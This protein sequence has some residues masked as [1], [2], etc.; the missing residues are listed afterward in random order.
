VTSAYVDLARAHAPILAIA[1]LFG[2]AAL[3]A[4]TPGARASWAMASF[5]ALI[6]AALGFDWALRVLLHDD[7]L[8]WSAEGLSLV[9]D[10][11]GVFALALLTVTA[12]VVVL[13]ALPLLE[14]FTSQLTPFACALAIA[15]AG[16]WC[17]AALAQDFT[18]FFLFVEIA[19]M[20]AVGAA[21][22]GPERGLNAAMRML[23]AGGVGAALLLLG[24]ALAARGVGSA[25][26][27]AMAAGRMAVPSLGAAGFALMIVALAIVGG[28][29]PFNAWVAASVGAAGGF[30]AAVVGVVGVSGAS[31]ALIRVAALAALAPQISDGV[32]LLLVGLGIA[33][34]AAGS[35]QAVGAV[36]I[37]R[38]AGYAGVAQ[39]GCVLLSASLGSPAGLEAAL[40]QVLAMAGAQL[41]II[42]GAAGAGGDGSLRAL[43]GLGR[44]A[45]LSA[46]ALTAGALS[47]MGAP[48][49]LT[50][51]G[52]WR[53][54]EAA[55][56][57]GWWWAAAAAIATSLAGVFYGGRLIERIYFRR[58]VSSTLDV[59]PRRW[60]AYALAPILCASIFVVVLGLEP[61]AAWRAAAHASAAM[62]ERLP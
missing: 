21:A 59:E 4:L 1:L 33:A 56:G 5:A 43:N 38:L 47:Y 60:R 31:L 42:A 10:G 34:V 11:V 9:A 45:P 12:A 17:G 41:A 7:P 52:R 27:A 30:G 62:L 50:F 44:R 2:G 18:T 28:A 49:T 29:P 26:F 57:V 6:A 15:S 24:A 37:L 51:L 25:D 48:L 16:G 8:A 3:A 39:L 20:A 35:L 58:A 13:G 14:N 19:W 40:L 36:N 55:L 61:G 23:I 46:A 32:A 53:L 54:I 22:L